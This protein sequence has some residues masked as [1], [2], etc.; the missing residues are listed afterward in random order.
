MQNKNIDRVNIFKSFDSLKGFRE[1]LM[2]KEKIVVPRK[3]LSEDDYEEMDKRI[4]L[5]HKGVMVRVVYYEDGEYVEKKGLVADIDI[6]YKR[7]IQIVEKIIKLDD[8]VKIDFI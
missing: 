5:I 7:K 4:K 2:N 6:E 8:I 3:V 1:Y